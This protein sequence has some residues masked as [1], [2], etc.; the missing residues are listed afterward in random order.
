MGFPD[1]FN[2][3]VGK[4]H[5]IITLVSLEKIVQMFFSNFIMKL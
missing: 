4:Y 5:F 1:D 2:T 3:A